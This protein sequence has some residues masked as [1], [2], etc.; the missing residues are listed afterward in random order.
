MT[1]FAYPYGTPTHFS[2]TTRAILDEAGYRTGFTSVHGPVVPG[3]DPLAL[4]RV[5]VEGGEGLAM[6]QQV[7]RGGMDSW[8]HVDHAVAAVRARRSPEAV[9]A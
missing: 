7:C 3:L 9:S 1:S 4:P 8:S 6:F 5:K 2:D